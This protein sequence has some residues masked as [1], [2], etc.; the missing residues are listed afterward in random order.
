MLEM[1][2]RTSTQP[3]ASTILIR[4]ELEYLTGICFFLF[5]YILMMYLYVYLAKIKKQSEEIDAPVA[6]IGIQCQTYN[7]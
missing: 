7:K 2:A 4:S 1:V 3:S 6:A 5:I